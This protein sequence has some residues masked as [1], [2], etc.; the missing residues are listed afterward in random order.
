MKNTP[1]IFTRG[2]LMINKSVKNLLQ[3]RVQQYAGTETDPRNQTARGCISLLP[4]A[5]RRDLTAKSAVPCRNPSE[6][7][8]SA[9]YHAAYCL[10]LSMRLS[11]S[12]DVRSGAISQM[13]HT[14]EM[15]WDFSESYAFAGT[16]VSE[17][18]GTG[19]FDSAVLS[20]RERGAAAISITD[21]CRACRTREARD[22]VELSVM[23]EQLLRD[24]RRIFG[25]GYNPFKHGASGKPLPDRQSRCHR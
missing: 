10:A 25:P 16:T 5:G 20:R 12:A 19:R 11:S 22:I 24:G 3:Q 15:R 9:I 8:L 2:T 1:V 17:S 7:A 21:S 23:I 18:A 4:A 14:A 6:T 13:T